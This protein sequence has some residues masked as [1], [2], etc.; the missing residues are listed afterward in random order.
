MVSRCIDMWVDSSTTAL[1]LSTAQSANLGQLAGLIG[2]IALCIVALCGA[3]FWVNK[4]VSGRVAF[5]LA[6]L[7]AAA[8]VVIRLIQ[9]L[10]TKT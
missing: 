1:T 2:G 7:G 4:S 5:S 3:F 9:L 6:A 8:T 10:S